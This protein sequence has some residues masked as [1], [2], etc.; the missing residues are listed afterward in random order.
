M[1]AENVVQESN[2]PWASPIVLAKKKDG[3]LRFC[4]DYRRLNAVTRK[5]V[6]PLPRIDDLLDKMRGK[7]VFSTLDVK[8]GYWQI[9]ME[10][11][12]REKTAFITSEGLYEF[13]VMP[14]GLCNAPA[15]FQRLMQRIL[16]SLEDFCSVYIDDVIVFSSSI[17]EH[18]DHLKQIFA[19]LQRVGLRLQPKKCIFGSQEVLYLGHLVS[20]KGIYPNPAKTKAVM[21]F[22]VPTNVKAVRRFLGL[23][24]Y[25]RRFVA[26]FAK[27]AS[28]LHALTRQDIPFQ[29]TAQCQEASAHLAPS[30]GLP[31]F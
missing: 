23:A 19:R 20:A 16:R 14:F 7:S 1:L 9:Q 8:T 24:S 31:K 21:E 15:T 27:V 13:Q 26:N 22:P 10:E 4:V 6:F 29:W 28:P 3:S 12:S 30:I 18:L 25:Y 5:D 17:E 2:S 11:N